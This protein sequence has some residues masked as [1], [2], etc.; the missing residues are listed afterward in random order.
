MTKGLRDS[1]A[2]KGTRGGGYL[3]DSSAWAIL[4]RALRNTTYGTGREDV[5]AQEFWAA[6]IKSAQAGSG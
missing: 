5:A 1:G 6:L 3:R 2:L 4:S